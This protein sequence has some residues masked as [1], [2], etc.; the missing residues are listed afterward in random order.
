MCKAKVFKIGQNDE[1]SATNG[2]DFLKKSLHTK[3]GGLKSLKKVSMHIRKINDIIFSGQPEG[4]L[5]TSFHRFTNADTS[6]KIDKSTDWKVIGRVKIKPPVAPSNE[7]KER[8]E[9][10]Y[11]NQLSA[12]KVLRALPILSS[13]NLLV[14]LP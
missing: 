10:V 5:G 4:D 2:K 6:A 12:H 8:V 3:N 7:A 1:E 14:T 11:L 13:A 9:K